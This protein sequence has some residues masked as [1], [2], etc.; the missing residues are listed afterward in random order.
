LRIPSALVVA[1]S[2][3]QG[4]FVFKITMEKKCTT[5]G[6]VK[7]LDEFYNHKIGKNGKRHECKICTINL[8]K[9]YYKK[10][11]EKFS[12][13]AKE[14]YKKNKEKFSQHAKEYYKKNKEKILLQKKEYNKKNKEKNNKYN[15]EYY[16]NNKEKEK[17]RRVLYRKKNKDKILLYRK[18][19]KRKKLKYLKERKK[20]DP[21]F[22]LRGCISSNIYGALKAQGYTKNTKTFNILKCEYNFFMDWLNG[23]A[24][25]GYTYGIGDLQ[26]DHVIP[27]SLAETEDE[28]ILLSHYSNYQLLSADENLA[29]S[30]R[31][32]NPLNLARVLEHHPNPDKIREIHARL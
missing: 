15:K 11:K 28:A 9:E 22:K 8:N 23:K 19:N 5:C 12:Q 21:I 29:K 24:S 31:Y 7:S 17:K 32:V 25:N 2:N 20:I 14:Y 13:H 6:E 26:L 27:I 4:I 18:K 16:K 3:S 30:N 10:N 1:R